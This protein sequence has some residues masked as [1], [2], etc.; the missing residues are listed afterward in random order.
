MANAL[1]RAAR[2]G[3]NPH[4]SPK[5]VPLGTYVLNRGVKG[6]KSPLDGGSRSG[7]APVEKAHGRCSACE[8]A[9]PWSHDMTLTELLTTIQS[10][11]RADKLRL[12]QLLAAD[13][14]RE[15]G[16]A[17]DLANKTVPIWSP[18]D[19]FDGAAT[20]LRVLDEDEVAS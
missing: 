4:E 16:I 14:A 12:I 6:A 1:D 8:R 2:G 10:L 3:Y 18:H 17:L 15:E 7:L 20:L 13:L 19:A 9:V 11:P 5:G